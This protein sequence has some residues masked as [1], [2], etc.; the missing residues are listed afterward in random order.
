MTL[1]CVILPNS[2]NGRMGSLRRNTFAPSHV[3]LLPVFLAHNLPLMSIFAFD[4]VLRL[5]FVFLTMCDGRR[6]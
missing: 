4:N 6:S 2:P 5:T 3:V 1:T